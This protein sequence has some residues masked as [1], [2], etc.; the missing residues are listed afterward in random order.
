MMDFPLLVSNHSSDM[1]WK[2]LFSTICPRQCLHLFSTKIK[3]SH[4]A[5]GRNNSRNK[6]HQIC[7]HY[8]RIKA[9]WTIACR[10]KYHLLTIFTPMLSAYIFLRAEY[11]RAGVEVFYICLGMV[12][13][14][15]RWMSPCD[16]LHNME[17]VVDSLYIRYIDCLAVN[18]VSVLTLSSFI[19]LMQGWNNILVEQ[20]QP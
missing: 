18:K 10:T 13:L 5:N 11:S 2:H 7:Y 3:F 4:M 20:V 6:V 1:L 16:I 17:I 8:I 15:C 12:V 14:Q 9:R 19:E